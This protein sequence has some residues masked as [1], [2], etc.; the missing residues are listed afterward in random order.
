MDELEQQERDEDAG[1]KKKGGKMGKEKEKLPK[2][3]QL[4]LATDSLPSPHAIRVIP[5]YDE[6]MKKVEKAE[7]AKGKRT[8]AVCN[9]TF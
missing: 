4:T 2:K 6:L 3:K 7:A 9:S 1:L 8:A 5:K